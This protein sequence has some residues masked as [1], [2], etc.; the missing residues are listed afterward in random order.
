MDI[1]ERIREAIHR[2]EHED[3]DGITNKGEGILNKECNCI[4]LHPVH[5]EALTKNHPDHI[6]RMQGLTEPIYLMQ[7]I[8]E[9]GIKR[10]GIP[11]YLAER[12]DNRDTNPNPCLDEGYSLIGIYDE[13][14]NHYIHEVSLKLLPEEE[15][16][17]G[18]N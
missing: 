9:E 11:V 16:E 18:T 14:N 3:I 5:Y 2:L 13:I 17:E 12:L 1:L 7:L 4:T 10:G 8:P 6:L 15:Q